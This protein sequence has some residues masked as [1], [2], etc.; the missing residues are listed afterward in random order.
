MTM[1]FINDVISSNK[2]QLEKNSIT[3]KRQSRF[4][5]EPE[6]VLNR[7]HQA[8]VGQDHILSTLGGL[9]HV[10]KADIT[11]KS[12]PLAVC[13][14]A[15]STGVGKTQTAKLLASSLTGQSDGLCRIDMGTLSQEHY[16]ASITGAPPGYVGSKEENTLFDIDK[17]QGSYSRPGVVLFDE[18]EKASKAV[19]R[20]LLNIMDSGFLRLA[21]GKKNIDFTNSIIIFTSNLGAKKT[22]AVEERHQS[23]WRKAFKITYSNKKRVDL[24]TQEIKK[25]FD[26]EFINRIDYLQVF[27]SLDDATLPKILDVVLEK[28]KARLA[29]KS[30]DL[31]VDMKTKQYLLSAYN[32]QYGARDIIRRVR[33]E[34]EPSIAKAMNT[35]QDVSQFS[36]ATLN[37]RITVGPCNNT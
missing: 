7:L 32:P 18:V 19:Q 36:T 21:A 33:T 17:I 15:G 25:H 34:M 2:E 11:D 29:K 13:F 8:I 3:A 23:G 16:S 14:F 28:L 1:P 31:N 6:S 27:N 5:F 24:V 26:P 22:Q 35:Y 12:R 20:A 30:I 9:L 37:G 10:I 4:I